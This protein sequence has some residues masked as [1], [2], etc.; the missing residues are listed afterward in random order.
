MSLQEK[1]AMKSS[2]EKITL[3]W[4]IVQ[5]EVDTNRKDITPCIIH[6]LPNV[7]HQSVKTQ[8]QPVCPVFGQQHSAQHVSHPEASIHD[9]E[10]K[11]ALRSTKNCKSIYFEK[12]SLTI[13]TFP[14]HLNPHARHHLLHLDRNLQTLEFSSITMSAIRKKRHKSAYIHAQLPSKQQ[15][16]TYLVSTHF[17]LRPCAPARF[18]AAAIFSQSCASAALYTGDECFATHTQ[19]SAGE[20]PQATMKSFL[21]SPHLPWVRRV[22]QP[23]KE[24]RPERTKDSLGW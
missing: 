6:Q 3:L 4:D 11:S 16:T 19:G 24:E 17:A 22:R 20:P 13:I 18:A 12:C 1:L 2:V 10:V 7:F 14:P 15:T 5:G 21:D 23:A 9:E 8:Q